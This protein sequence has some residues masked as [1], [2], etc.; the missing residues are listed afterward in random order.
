VQSPSGPISAQHF[1]LSYLIYIRL[2]RNVERN[3]LMIESIK[4]SIGRE[5]LEGRK[6]KPQDLTRLYEIIVQN[7]TELLHLAGLEDDQIFQ[8]EIDSQ[9]KGY[10]AFR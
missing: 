2:T 7:F 6:L 8:Q 3:L 5:N 9:L 4:Q 1:L 10:R